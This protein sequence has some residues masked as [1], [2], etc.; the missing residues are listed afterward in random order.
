MR[1]N[2]LRLA[3]LAFALSAACTLYSQDCDPDF[4]YF[5][6]ATNS[7]GTRLEL[8]SDGG[9]L[10]AGSTD[11]LGAGGDDI[12]VLRSDSAGNEIWH[13]TLGQADDDNASA[14]IKTS[15]GNFL[16]L[17]SLGSY[18]NA[19]M[20]LA[21]IDGD[22]NLLWENSYAVS[23]QT[24]HAEDVVED[25]Q[26]NFLIAGW[27][28]YPGSGWDNSR[29]MAIAKFSPT[30]AFINQFTYNPYVPNW[31]SSSGYQPGFGLSKALTIVFAPDGNLLLGGTSIAS[32]FITP[33]PSNLLLLKLT[34]SF[35]VLWEKQYFGSDNVCYDGNAAVAI[36]PMP[37]GNIYVANRKEGLCYDGPPEPVMLHKFNGSGVQIWKKAVALGQADD[38]KPT[39]DG[40]LI[41]AKRGYELVKVDTAGFLIWS[42][43]HYTWGAYGEG[44]NRLH[45][46][47]D[48]GYAF[49]ASDY[50]GGGNKFVVVRTDS[51]GNSC[52]NRLSGVVY[53]DENANCQYDAGETTLPHALVGINPLTS[54]RY[55]D[56][57][58]KYVFEAEIGT[59]TVS[60]SITG[61]FWQTACPAG[62]SR[63]LTFNQTY[64]VRDT[65]HF[66]YTPQ[67]VCPVLRLQSGLS[68]RR[69]CRGGQYSMQ[70]CNVGAAEASNVELNLEWPDDLQ[71]LG[72][73]VPF[74]QNGSTYTFAFNDLS[75][76]EC[77]TLLIADSVRCDAMLGDEICLAASVSAAQS[78]SNY[79]YALT[80]TLCRVLTN[81]Y[82]PNE[83]RGAVDNRRDCFAAA[84]AQPERLNY[85]IHFQNTGNDT[86]LRV[87]VLDTLDLNK[88]DLRTLEPGPA[89][90][91]Y[92]LK[93]HGDRTLAW[94][95]DNINLTDTLTS[96]A[97][98][99]GFV[100]FRIATKQ[101]MGDGETLNN[102]A[103]IYFDANAPVLTTPSTTEACVLP[104]APPPCEPYVVVHNGLS[105]TV[106]PMDSNSDGVT[107][108]A[109]L[110][111]NVSDFVRAG[112]SPC[113][114]GKLDY[115]MVK[116]SEATGTPPSDTSV[117]FSCNELG[118]QLVQVWVGDEAGNWNY[119][120]TYVIVQ[121]PTGRCLSGAAGLPT[122]CAN[123]Q[124]APLLTVMNGFRTSL[125]PDGQGGAQ[126]RI[127]APPFLIS[128]SDN[129]SM[130]L[131]VRMVKTSESGGQPPSTAYVNFGCDEVGVQSVEIWIGDDNGNWQHAETY[132]LVEDN[133]N[134]CNGNALPLSCSPDVIP[135]FTLVRDGLAAGI[136]AGPQG[137]YAVARANQFVRSNKDNC[138]PGSTMRISKESDPLDPQGAKASVKFGCNELGTQPVNIWVKDQAGNWSRTGA[139]ILVQDNLGVCGQAQKRAPVSIPDYKAELVQRAAAQATL[140]SISPAPVLENLT[141]RPNPAHQAFSLSGT[142]KVAGSGQVL[143]YDNF[144]RQVKTLL[145]RQSL[146]A[147]PFSRS[148]DLGEL[149]AGLYWCVWQAENAVQRVAVVKQ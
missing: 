77:Q 74:S 137:P 138:S 3:S 24:W 135:P 104:P 96:V 136:S 124:L 111:L 19:K 78:C 47:P 8:T 105:A 40:N 10:I 94:T 17:G 30:G 118:T 101:P 28:E 123:D 66:G 146:E 63:T 113:V 126:V 64:Q 59:Y 99:E 98:S 43:G 21:K 16:V 67:E 26:G 142:V 108:M 65:L 11:D 139:Y 106:Q 112:S 69:I 130:A 70:V 88:F 132:V 1:L 107:D 44:K 14:V 72:A 125:L 56:F 35:S 12:Y 36:V 97:G 122:D 27:A 73:N 23:G 62:G 7:P 93:I 71:F 31:G 82:D 57:D 81:S 38:M 48:G 110:R 46:L 42:A 119:S 29:D 143:L 129:C 20:Y 51:L 15:D 116:S 58:G 91:L 52:K 25:A 128:K 89:S 121:D 37:D 79:V 83:K 149:P 85:L 39:A 84:D 50:I 145:P 68:S 115:R 76:G 133:Y 33:V 5:D 114:K 13:R 131:K 103:S 144:G 55:T 95:F 60:S 41:I 49:S 134:L 90:H 140:R 53:F 100:S 86:A 117:V 6:H 54:Y 22:G 87:V 127:T 34:P 120:E 102:R 18:Y 141:V 2:P 148:F 80:D 92:S 75:I 45:Q 32:G 9:Y 147:G 61:N 4:Y 109:G